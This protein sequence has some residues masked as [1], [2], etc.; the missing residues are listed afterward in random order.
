M[1]EGVKDH[2]EQKGDFQNEVEN[3]IDR[4]RGEYDMSY[5][6]LIGVLQI[7][8]MNLFLELVGPDLDKR[9]LEP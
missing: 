9:F 5:A 7:V 3:V 4:F 8:Q 6:D 2:F 1:S